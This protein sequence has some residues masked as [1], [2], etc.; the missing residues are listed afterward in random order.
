LADWMLLCFETSRPDLTT[1]HKEEDERVGDQESALLLDIA[2]V[3]R[4]TST[5]LTNQ[6]R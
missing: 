3:H 5:F 4:T 6:L 2:E 1:T